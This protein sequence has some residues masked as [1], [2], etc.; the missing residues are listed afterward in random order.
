VGS[1]VGRSVG[2]SVGF[3]VGTSVAGGSVGS[4]G[5]P[6]NIPQPAKLK[7]IDASSNHAILHKS[8]DLQLFIMYILSDVI[9]FTFFTKRAVFG[10]P[11]ITY[12]NY[13]KLS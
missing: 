6:G 1:S 11:L 13:F 2:I 9:F 8:C 4:V 5:S 10:R 3:S 7:S 12:V